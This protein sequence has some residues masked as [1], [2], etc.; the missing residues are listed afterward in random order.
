MVSLFNID[1]LESDILEMENRIKQSKIGN[2]NRYEKTDED[3]EVKE[4]P[5]K[6]IILMS[7]GQGDKSSFISQAENDYFKKIDEII[8]VLCKNFIDFPK[9]RILEA[10][11]FNTF[12]LEKT[13][14]FLSNPDD[15]S[16]IS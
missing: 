7:A 12:D 5:K 2:D 8:E 13:F 14:K 15:H 10:L 9:S 4:A 6:N 16:G 3:N 11:R 1:Y